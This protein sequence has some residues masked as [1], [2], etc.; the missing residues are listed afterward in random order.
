PAE[1][2][3]SGI[4]QICLRGSRE[5]ACRVEVARTL[6]GERFVV[7]KGVFT[8]RRDRRFVQTL[9]IQLTALDASQLRA[10]QCGAA[11]EILRATLRPGVELSVMG[12][13]GV[14]MNWPFVIRCRVDVRRVRECAVEVILGFFR[15]RSYGPRETLSLPGRLN[16]RR[17]VS[18]ERARL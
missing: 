18:G 15:K 16:G 2:C 8:G 14:D 12:A 10:D 17:P 13:H 6:T 9:G 7:G 3:V 11:L 4:A 1:I 5:T